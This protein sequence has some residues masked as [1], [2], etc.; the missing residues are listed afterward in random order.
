MNDIQAQIVAR[1]EEILKRMESQSKASIFSKDFWY[2]S[3][4]EWSMKNEKFKTNMFRFVDVLPSLN[5]GDEVARH[6]KEYFS[7]N[8]EAL[9]PVF[10]VGL[11]IGSLAPGLMAGAIRKNVTAMAKMF[12]TGE[13][14]DEALPVLKKARKAKMTF[15]V[16]ILGEATLSEKEA[17][18]YSSKCMEL[19]TWLAK[20]SEKWDEVPQIDRD[21]EGALPKVNVS[22]KM[23][24]LFSQ[25]KDLA[26]DESKKALKD[27]LRPIFRAGMEK[28]LFVNLDMEQYSVK[29][30]T[31]EVFTE[32]INE[33]EFKS[34]KFFGI[35]IQ[36]YLRD[37]FQDVKEL[38]DIAK[39][40]GTPFWIRLVKGAYWDYETIEAEQRGWPIPVYTKKA[41]SDD[42]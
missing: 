42:K 30:L 10:N 33:P 34:Y 3:I 17:R 1:G 8:G 26:W 2:G 31:L 32:L 24:A 23:T 28:G 18:E 7:E 27:R 36:A 19:I 20:D 11:G 38:T 4:M 40:R 14:P 25:I 29:H 37:S 5:S 16:D 15:T 6:L 12:I 13:S 35:V 9:P 39:S 21:H 41:E 22:V